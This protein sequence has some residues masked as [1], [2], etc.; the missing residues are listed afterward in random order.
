MK[1]I[2]FSLLLSAASSSYAQVGI[3]TESPHPSSALDIRSDNKG[4]LIPKVA[5]LDRLDSTTIVSPAEALLV[6]N[7]TLNTVLAPGFYY[8]SSGSWHPVAGKIAD[9]AW[10]TSGNTTQDSA[11]IGTI[12]EIPLVLAAHSERTALF[13]PG[14]GIALGKNADAEQTSGIAF[15]NVAYANGLNNI[16]IGKGSNSSVSNSIAVGTYANA[17]GQDG[18]AVGTE[19][20]AKSLNTVAVGH[21]AEASLEKATAVGAQAKASGEASVVVGAFSEATAKKSFALGP[22]TSAT[23]ENAFA[24]GIGTK[25]SQPN[26]IILGEVQDPASSTIVTP[27]LVGIGTVAPKA[28]LDIHDDFKL[29]ALGT[30]QKGVY[31]FEHIFP[32][33]TI[34]G[35][36]EMIEINLPADIRLQTGNYKAT[37][38]AT[39]NPLFPD[40]AYINWVK[41][42]ASDNTKVRIR[43][44]S[45]SGSQT[46]QPGGGLYFTITE[47]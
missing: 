33:G 32:A 2:V 42:D 4:I 46:I 26:T 43:W 19:A 35:S 10:K 9:S 25:A 24:L 12:N 40:Q 5:L 44:Q 7:T 34:I 1:K 3:N 20:A 29:G 22:N 28:R 16:A 21:L 18:V 30:V 41:L 36:A 14:G 27:A 8:Y 38:V 13:Y 11:F 17:S 37:I 45:D 47:F 6:Y 23:A 39:P 15:G 31:S